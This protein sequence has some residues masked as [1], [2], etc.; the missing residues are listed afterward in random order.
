MQPNH[1]LA[2]PEAVI[3]RPGDDRVEPVLTVG[4]PVVAAGSGGSSTSIATGGA[5]GAGGTVTQVSLPA[6][7]GGTPTLLGLLLLVGA[8]LLLRARRGPD[9]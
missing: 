3:I 2:V 1:T 5:A 9:G 6:T 7:G 4:V 8:A